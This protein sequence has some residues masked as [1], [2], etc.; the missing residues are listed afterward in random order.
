MVGRNSV[1]SIRPWC[2]MCTLPDPWWSEGL[3]VDDI[4][5]RRDNWY[6]RSADWPVGG[7]SS[8]YWRLLTPDTGILISQDEDVEATR[9]LHD[10]GDLDGCPGINVR[11]RAGRN[12]SPMVQQNSRL[13]SRGCHCRFDPMDKLDKLDP[14]RRD[15]DRPNRMPPGVK[16]PL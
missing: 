16:L 8:H 3:A 15:R 14:G 5:D 13:Q 11:A 7:L 6:R 9:P 4:T 1:N 12:S 10:V 2:C